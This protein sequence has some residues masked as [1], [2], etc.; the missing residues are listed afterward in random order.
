M[1]MG[2]FALRWWWLAFGGV[3][4]VVWGLQQAPAALVSKPTNNVLAPVRASSA[5]SLRPA[6]QLSVDL[7]VT[8]MPA[9]AVH[10]PR[11]GV[12]PQGFFFDPAVTYP[13]GDEQAS[14]AVGDISGDGRS[15]VVAA[16]STYGADNAVLIFRQAEDGTLL[17]PDRYQTAEYSQSS[18]IA[19]VDLDNDE[20]QD[21]VVG[22][23]DS[24]IVLLN[25][26]S[27]MTISSRAAE[28]QNG[29]ARVGALDVN[30]DG[31]KDIAAVNFEYGTDVFINDGAG[32]LTAGQHVPTPLAIRDVSVGDLTNDGVDDLVVQY[33]KP[34]LLIYP[35]GAGSL[36]APIKLAYPVDGTEP[37]THVL[38]DFN[39]DGRLDVGMNDQRPRDPYPYGPHYMRVYIR[40]AEGNLSVGW[41]APTTRTPYG[42]ALAAADLDGNGR[43]DLVSIA[44][45]DKMSYL[46]QGVKGFKPEVRMPRLP[47]WHQYANNGFAVGNVSG[48]ECLDV[49]VPSLWATGYG[50]SVYRGRNC[51]HSLAPKIAAPSSIPAR[52]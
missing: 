32:A 51:S 52:R 8:N 11:T 17:A 14:V 13:T 7:N 23:H 9:I 5:M 24:L 38:A 12:A 29:Y 45:P 35:A 48:D 40:D 30:G 16:V 19:I 42:S 44:A 10:A 20:D 18:A 43:Y 2:S 41:R 49:V 39:G 1:E 50:I 3:G 46:L 25:S 4:L 27:G 34:E 28:T 36:G 37:D 6:R 15:D 26:P 47:D 33:Y 21:I 31:F 22:Y